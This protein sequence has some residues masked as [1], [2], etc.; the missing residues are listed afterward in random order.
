MTL[1]TNG[2]QFSIDKIIFLIIKRNTMRRR[3]IVRYTLNFFLTS[4]FSRDTALIFT[5]TNLFY[6]LLPLWPKCSTI[7]LERPPDRSY[8][9]LDNAYYIF[10]TNAIWTNVKNK[11]H[12]FQKLHLPFSEINDSKIR[13][14][15]KIIYCK[16]N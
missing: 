2:L 11:N 13:T 5:Q 4:E 12:I 1:Y 16:R 14:V 15:F 3:N 7:C 8:Y 10:F 9:I 6:I